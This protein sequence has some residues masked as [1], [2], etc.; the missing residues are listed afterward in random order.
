MKIIQLGNGGGLNPQQTNSSFL[1]D[2]HND[3][4]S[5]LLFDCGFNI[6]ARLAKLEEEDPNFKI[7]N[8]DYIFLSHTHD[9][10]VGN[11]ETLSYWNYFKNNKIMTTLCG[12]NEV[13]DYIKA[14]H[15]QILEAGKL[16]NIPLF[17]GTIITTRKF[18]N[19]ELNPIQGY[20]GASIAHGLVVTNTNTNTMIFISGDTKANPAI[21][22]AVD[23]IRKSQ[24]IPPLSTLYF[25]DFS[26]W[27]A[28]TRNVH[29]C[30][31]D[32]TIEYSPAFQSL[33]TKYHTGTEE[34]NKS[35][36]QL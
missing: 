4:S 19:L 17:N 22:A 10:H 12:S 2:L 23:T 1:I 35:W 32:F 28:P 20:H 9:D 34:F 24:G 27:N 29:A 13:L 6:V 26:N 31:S 33:C 3:H 5:Y 25:H 14:K 15:N 21:E 11:Y 18:D 36:Q 8:I 7:A 30:E 16:I